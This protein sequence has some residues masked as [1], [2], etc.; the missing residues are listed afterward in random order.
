MY[1][2]NS[3]LI[4]KNKKVFLNRHGDIPDHFIRLESELL[5]IIFENKE[6]IIK[7]QI[8]REPHQSCEKKSFSLFQSKDKNTTVAQSRNA[9]EHGTKTNEKHY[10]SSNIIVQP[11]SSI[12]KSE[13]S[14]IVRENLGSL[15]FETPPKGQYRNC[16]AKMLDTERL[17]CDKILM[18]SPTPMK[19]IPDEP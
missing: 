9:N 19:I 2:C 14:H 6:N 7:S 3:D 11:F 15:I 18:I 13:R 17:I 10:D 5:E 8:N 4:S 12:K 16:S 1:G